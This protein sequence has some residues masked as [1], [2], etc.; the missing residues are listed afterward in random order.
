[1][2]KKLVAGNPAR[3]LEPLAILVPWKTAA[4][5]PF[6][7]YHQIFYVGIEL[8][9]NASCYKL[10]KISAS[11]STS[12]LQPYSLPVVYVSNLTVLHIWW[13]RC[14]KGLLPTTRL[15]FWIFHCVVAWQWWIGTWH[16]WTCSNFTNAAVC[17]VVLNC[18]SCMLL[19]TLYVLWY[20][21]NTQEYCLPCTYDWTGFLYGACMPF[22]YGLKLYRRMHQF[23]LFPLSD[24]TRYICQSRISHV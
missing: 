2:W 24:K 8:T 5:V 20:Y 14:S 18:A 13:Q 11:N 7:P 3:V 9:E 17:C 12:S 21:N 1:M 23:P 10:N 16:T 22:E 19:W 6:S 4:F 15:E